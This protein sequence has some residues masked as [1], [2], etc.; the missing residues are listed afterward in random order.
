MG[1]IRRRLCE[2]VPKGPLFVSVLFAVSPF[3][4]LKVWLHDL[5]DYIFMECSTWRRMSQLC[6]SECRIATKEGNIFRERDAL[7]GG[8]GA[9]CRHVFSQWPDGIDE[10][11]LTKLC[12]LVNHKKI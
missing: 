9:D 3:A 7:L 4:I 12:G 8:V 6:R 11:Q 10:T 2:V 1:E 5:S